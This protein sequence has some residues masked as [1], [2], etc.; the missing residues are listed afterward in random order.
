MS[1]SCQLCFPMLLDPNCVV[2][3]WNVRGLNSPARKQVVKDLVAYHRCKI[4]CI[5]E[6]KLQ[7]VGDVE[8]S[9]I[10][11]SEFCSN[12]TVLH[13]QG[14]RGGLVVECSMDCYSLLHVEIKQHSITATIKRLVDDEMWCVT[15]VYC[16]QGDP[17]KL[18]FMQELKLIKQTV[19]GRWIVLGDFNLICR[20]QDKSNEHINLRLLNGFRQVLDELELREFHL[21]GRKYTWSSGT[22]NLTQ[23]KIDHVSASR[24]W[25]LAYPHCYLQ[26]ISSSVSDHCPILLTSSPPQRRFKG[27]RFEAFWLRMPEFH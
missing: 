12:F 14:T 10:L 26:A 16:S 5:H 13:A 19:H 24:E 4:V 15:G 9:N 27:F 6:M 7:T 17:E 1:I 3:S 18:A 2:L 23:T 8:I 22:T 21:Q 11:G 25:E 20:A